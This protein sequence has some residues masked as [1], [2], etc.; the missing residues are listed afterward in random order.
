MQK[1]YILKEHGAKDQ[2]VS[3]KHLVHGVGQRTL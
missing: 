1:I 3:Q 2:K